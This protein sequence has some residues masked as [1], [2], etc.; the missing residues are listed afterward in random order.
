MRGG[1]LV[2]GACRAALILGVGL[3]VHAGYGLFLARDLS[4]TSNRGAFV[5]SAAFE[6]GG[7]SF[8]PLGALVA[9]GLGCLAIA[10]AV[11]RRPSPLFIAAAGN[12]VLG[13]QVLLQYGR[14]TNLLG[15][16]GSNLSLAILAAAGLVVL[17]L[18]LAEE[19]RRGEPRAAGD[20]V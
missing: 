20:S 11:A 3:V 5:G 4:F 16:R 1:G 9:L 2:S 7:A 14:A 19:R 17:G 18:V 13:V 8:N 10:G 12:A 6:V 15:S